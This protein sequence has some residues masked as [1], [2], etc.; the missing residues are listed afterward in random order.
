MDQRAFGFPHGGFFPP[1]FF[2]PF[3]FP[4]RRFFPFF[5][6]SPF[7]F[8]FFRGEEGEGRNPNL[9]AQHHCQVGDSMQSLARAYNV[10]KPILEAV[11]SHLPTTNE[12][13]PGSVVNIPRM[14]NM[15]CHKMYLEKEMSPNE[16]I[17]PYS[18]PSVP[19]ATPTY[20]MQQLPNTNSAYTMQQSSNATMSPQP[21]PRNDNS[22]APFSGFYSC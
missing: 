20:S 21:M 7:F 4:R 15:Y 1:P 17:S 14:D 18:T 19:Y 9:Y 13:A 16:A 22:S 2:N 6:I 12:L 5:F 10:P 3:F 8:P 11:N